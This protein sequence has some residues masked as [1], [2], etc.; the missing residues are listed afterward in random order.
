MNRY[1]EIPLEPPE[2][3]HYDKIDKSDYDMSLQADTKPTER[4]GSSSRGKRVAREL[5]LLCLAADLSPDRIERISRAL[6]G[7][8]D[9][10]YFLSL[11]NFH[12]AAP[13]VSRNLLSNSLTQHIPHLYREQMKN[14]YNNFIY[15]NILLNEELIRV[16]SAFK[17][18][19][20]SAIVLKGTV[21]AE[22]IYGNPGLRPVTDM[23]IM[24]HPEDV[25]SANSLLLELGYF[26]PPYL[27]EN[28]DHP[29]HETPYWKDAQFR[30]IIELHKNIDDPELLPVPQEQIWQRTQQYPV[31]GNSVLV[32]SPEDTLLLLCNHFFKHHNHMLM[33]L[34]DISELIR[35]Y[36]GVMDWEYVLS[37]ARSWQ[38]ETS[39]YFTFRWARDLLGAS[40]PASVTSALKPGWLRLRVLSIFLNRSSIISPIEGERVRSETLVLFRGLLMKHFSQTWQVLYRHRGVAK[41]W[42]RLSM[43][44]WTILVFVT[45][46]GRDVSAIFRKT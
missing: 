1:A 28:W 29:F 32:L 45:A 38:A 8:M 30:L 36:D 4:P 25:S 18:H 46:V 3:T 27:K 13:L 43:V 12:G 20:I 23:D 11:V 6:S 44:M 33:A 35:K 37:A 41:R 17:Q 21:L 26:Q 9:W 14:L 22:Q 24:V 42:G 40:L 10:Q 39:A 34:C 19:G 16:L 15:R 2:L 7:N 5:L 31:P